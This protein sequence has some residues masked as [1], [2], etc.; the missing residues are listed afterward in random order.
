MIN[1]VYVCVIYLIEIF[2]FYIVSN[3]THTSALSAVP[4]GTFIEFIVAIPVVI[5]LVVAPLFAIVSAARRF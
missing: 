1:A 5:C 2:V 3:S 4:I